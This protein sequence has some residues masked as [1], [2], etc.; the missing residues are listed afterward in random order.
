MTIG[1]INFV[2][3][4]ICEEIFQFLDP[5]A[6]TLLRQI[7]RKFKEI[8]DDPKWELHWQGCVEK[9]FS[10]LKPM[11]RYKERIIWIRLFLE[12]EKRERKINEAVSNNQKDISISTLFDNAKIIIKEYARLKKYQINHIFSD[13]TKNHVFSALKMLEICPANN[14]VPEIQYY[15]GLCFSGNIGTLA[16]PMEAFK[17]YQKAAEHG[18]AE[19]Q[20]L[21]GQLYEKGWGMLVANPGEAFK[22]YKKAAKQGLA[23]AQNNLGRCYEMGSGALTNPGKAFKHYQKAADQDWAS[24]QNTLGRCYEMA[25]GTPANPGEAFKH[26]QKAADQG[27]AEA[28]NTLGRCYEMGIGAPINPEKALK[29]YQ[30]AAE[31]GWAPAQQKLE[32]LSVKR[33]K[34]EEPVPVKRQKL[35]NS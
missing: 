2:P 30:K 20:F 21:L 11:Y 26:Y 19:A 6:S 23:S 29:Y 14:S 35:E 13:K 25:I 16:D 28:Q 3:S 15:L 17:Y 9:R 4:Y 12:Y 7:S 27:L 32:E 34:T 24:A 1:P 33:K 5:Q 22:Y 31:Q 8:I 10:Y 18:V